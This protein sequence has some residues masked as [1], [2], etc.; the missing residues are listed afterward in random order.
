MRPLSDVRSSDRTGRPRTKEACAFP[1]KLIVSHELAMTVRESWDVAGRGLVAWLHSADAARP[2]I[3]I[4]AKPGILIESVVAVRNSIAEASQHL[5]GRLASCPTTRQEGLLEANLIKL[6]DSAEPGACGRRRGGFC[7]GKDTCEFAHDKDPFVD[8]VMCAHLRVAILQRCL[9]TLL[10]RD[11]V[12]T[13]MTDTIPLPRPTLRISPQPTTILPLF[14][15]RPLR[16]LRF[17]TS[18]GSSSSLHSPLH[19]DSR[20][21][22]IIMLH[23]QPE[24]RPLSSARIYQIIAQ[25]RADGTVSAGN[26]ALTTWR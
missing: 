1:E 3:T 13:L 7:G 5:D 22:R 10:L 2:A 25:L 16:S 24:T 26:A 15:P 18:A 19:H 21:S 12:N 23:R 8:G 6:S 17:S 4:A 9:K 11:R 20:P 14:L